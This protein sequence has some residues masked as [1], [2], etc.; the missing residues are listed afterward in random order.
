MQKA[1][2]V[3][4]L[5]ILA[6][7]QVYLS[8]SPLDSVNEFVKDFLSVDVEN[9]L[10]DASRSIKNLPSL[11]TFAES[12]VDHPILLL[13]GGRAVVG[14]YDRV[15]GAWG[16]FAAFAHHGSWLLAKGTSSPQHWVLAGSVSH[17]IRIDSGVGWSRGS[18]AENEKEA[19]GNK[20]L[21]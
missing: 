16:V 1:H 19:F 18:H 4:H 20:L 2:R 7:V 14:I 10:E 3:V 15:T 13:A 12:L 11:K 21:G 6:F 9:L 5:S 8:V 17:K